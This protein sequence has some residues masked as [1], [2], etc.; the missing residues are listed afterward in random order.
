MYFYISVYSHRGICVMGCVR[1][2]AWLSCSSPML[3]SKRHVIINSITWALYTHIIPYRIRCQG[4][5]AC[6]HLVSLGNTAKMVQVLVTAPR[7]NTEDSVLRGM[8]R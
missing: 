8:E 2:M 5:D 3:F 1:S 7:V 6:V 4:P